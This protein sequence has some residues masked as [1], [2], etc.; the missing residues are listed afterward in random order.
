MTAW[1]WRRLGNGSDLGL[2]VWKWQR[3]NGSWAWPLLDVVLLGL[4]SLDVVHLGLAPLGV[5]CLGLAP[6]GVARLGLAPLGVARLGVASS[7]C[8]PL[9]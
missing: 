2:A 9:V 7:G 1:G 8:G 5:A 4:A 6:L 3:G